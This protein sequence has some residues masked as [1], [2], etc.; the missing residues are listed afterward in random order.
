MPERRDK[1]VRGPHRLNF[2][3]LLSRSLRVRL[4]RRNHSK[5]EFAACEPS[6]GESCAPATKYCRWIYLPVSN[7]YKSIRN[8]GKA[9]GVAINVQFDFR[10]SVALPF[11]KAH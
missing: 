11:W 10:P 4:F 9:M 3:F 2:P 6:G 5:L 1:H 7:Q 8:N